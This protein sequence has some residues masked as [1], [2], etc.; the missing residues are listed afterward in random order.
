MPRFPTNQKK[1]EIAARQKQVAALLLNRVSQ[2]DIADK[3]NVD[4]ATICRDVKALFKKYSA[5]CQEDISHH[6][7]REL[8]ELDRMELEASVM[9]QQFKGDKNKNIPT[10]S[11][12]ANKWLETR[13]KIKD[14]RSKLLGLDKLTAIT[15]QKMLENEKTSDDKINELKNAILSSINKTE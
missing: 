4:E 12:E 8:A 9:Y 10:N 3:L 5:E 2:V 14:R 11:K 1:A 6:V 15:V 13:L 7:A